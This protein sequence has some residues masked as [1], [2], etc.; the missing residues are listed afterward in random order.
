MIQK[1]SRHSNLF[2]NFSSRKF[3]ARFLATGVLWLLGQASETIC[4]ETSFSHSTKGRHPFI[5]IIQPR[6][7][8]LQLGSPCV[9]TLLL[10]LFCAKISIFSPFHFYSIT[11]VISSRYIWEKEY[12]VSTLG[13]VI[14]SQ[15]IWEKEHYIS[16]LDRPGPCSR[17]VPQWTGYGRHC[18]LGS[19]EEY[20]DF[21]L[22]QSY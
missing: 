1:H 19:P 22:I 5:W 6:N 11:C 4:L 15:Y 10:G 17:V 21:Y 14:S 16:T 7:N 20:F 13:R 3:I 9:P 12:Y 8:L 2:V 18:M